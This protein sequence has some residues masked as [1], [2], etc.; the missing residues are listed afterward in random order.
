MGRGK[1]GP[2]DKARRKLCQLPAILD[3]DHRLADR[4]R[5]RV[6]AMW[7]FVLSWG[8]MSLGMLS[9]SFAS[10]VAAMA[11]GA[12]VVGLGMGPAIP[13]DIAHLMAAVPTS[14]S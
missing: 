7:L 2:T 4:L 1:L 5:G 10:T 8:A 11:L 9:L 13:N 12:V 3:A 14:A 6:S